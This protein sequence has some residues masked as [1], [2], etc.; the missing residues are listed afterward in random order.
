MLF[1]I[2]IFLLLLNYCICFFEEIRN[3]NYNIDSEIKANIRGFNLRGEYQ[4]QKNRIIN[5]ITNRM[6]RKRYQNIMLYSM[7][8]RNYYETSFFCNINNFSIEYNI[9]NMSPDELKSL[10]VSFYSDKYFN[11]GSLDGFFIILNIYKIDKELIIKDIIDKLIL[12][13]PSI[14]IDTY[15][16]NSCNYYNIS[17]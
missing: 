16:N 1:K 14:K 17:W 5:I 6:Y 3:E 13:I 9:N 8:G 15:N 11:K 7:I 4:I 2:L 12:S 10:F